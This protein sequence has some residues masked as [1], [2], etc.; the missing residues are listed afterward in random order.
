M[1]YGGDDLAKKTLDEIN[2][3]DPNKSYLILNAGSG[4]GSDMIEQSRILPKAKFIGIEY[5]QRY[6]DLSS[7]II[8]AL[9]LSDRIKIY[10][11]NIA[12]SDHM[13]KIIHREGLFDSAYSNL[14]LLHIKEKTKV[15]SLIYKLLKPNSIFR[16]EDYTKMKETNLIFAT[17][18][19]DCQNLKTF[20]EMIDIAR[21]V[22][23]RNNK[24][25]DLSDK[26]KK[27]TLQRLFQNSNF[28]QRKKTAKELFFSDIAKYFNN[29]NGSGG[30]FIHIK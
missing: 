27:F 23:F 28:K 17:K 8:Q 22:G 25:I 14:V 21:S 1:R 11:A 24:F 18:K 20:D 16:N 10:N 7:K 30:V 3:N 12:D 4:F 6:A 9:N 13:K 29:Y 2:T 26:W 15:Y 5:N 19:I